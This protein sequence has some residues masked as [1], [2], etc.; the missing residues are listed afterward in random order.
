MNIN[1]WPL[2]QKYFRQVYFTVEDMAK[3][4]PKAAKKKRIIKKWKKRFPTKELIFDVLIYK[5]NP[6]LALM[7]CK[8]S[9]SYKPNE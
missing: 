6:F 8:H 2:L 4:Y 3:K 9:G 5:N 1:N 7:S